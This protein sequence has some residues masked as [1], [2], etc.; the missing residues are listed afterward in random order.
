MAVVICEYFWVT[1]AHEAVLYYSDLFR[2]TLRG[3]DV[4]G[5]IPD[6][7]K[8][9]YRSNR[10]LRTISW[11]VCVGCAYVGPKPA[12]Y[13]QEIEQYLSKPNYEKLKT[14]VKR[15]MDQQIRARKIEARSRRIETGALVK[16]RKGK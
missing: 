2:I 14:M 1:G 7:T 9:C 15:C 8:F 4:Q 12:I 13:E 16:T 3:D 5:F 11:K 6:G 10:F